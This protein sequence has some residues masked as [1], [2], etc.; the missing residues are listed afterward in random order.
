MLP[1]ARRRLQISGVC[2]KIQLIRGLFPAATTEGNDEQ[3]ISFKQVVQPEECS[4]KR[5]DGGER[6]RI[7]QKE[8]SA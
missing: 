3:V 2:L 1:Q 8:K 6:S 7:I 4:C 5:T